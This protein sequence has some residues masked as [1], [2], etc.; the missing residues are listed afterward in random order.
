[1]NRLAGA[2]I[3]IGLGVHGLGATELPFECETA[4]P[5]L[6]PLTNEVS[7]PAPGEVPYQT[8]YDWGGPRAEVDLG[9]GHIRPTEHEASWYWEWEAVAELPLYTAPDGAHWGWFVKGY[10]MELATGTITPVGGQGMVE[11][12][13]ETLS[14]IVLDLSDEGW[15]RFRYAKP[16]DTRDGTAWIHACQLAQAAGAPGFEPWDARFL[17]G[18]ISPLYFRTQVPHALRTGPGIEHPRLRWIYGERYHLEPFETAG[19]WMR[20]KLV[21]PSNYCGDPGNVKNY[22]GWV[23]W[24][25]P[26]KGPWVWYYTRGC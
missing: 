21:E 14:F 1:M 26:D 19:E 12:G 11:T 23:K 17:S 13:Y 5:A 10:V 22:E 9:I 15:L 20:V 8:I 24:R 25:S 3:L 16:S 4:W 6:P 18:E 2:T 7:R